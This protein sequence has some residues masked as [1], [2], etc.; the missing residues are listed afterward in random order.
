MAN[1]TIQLKFSTLTGKPATLAAGEPAYSYQSN[2]FFI[3]TPDGTGSINIGGYYYTSTLDSA[4]NSATGGT[5][6]K[7]DATGNASFNYIFANIVGTIEGT[8]AQATKLETPRFFN[9]TGDV[10]AVSASFDG[11]ANANFTLELT[12]TGVTNGTYGGATQIPVITVDVDG[13]ITSASNTSIS[14]DLNIKAD[15]GS[16][17][18]SLST[19]TLTFV[20]GDGI[21]TTIGPTDNVSFAV[22]NT[23]IRT[24]GPQTIDGTLNITGNLNVT[25]NVTTFGAEDLVINDPII[26]LANNN[27]GDVLDIGFVGKYDDGTSKELGL[28]HHAASDK[29]YLFTG[30]EGAVEDNNILNIADPTIVTATLIANLEGGTVS[31]L[32]SAISVADGGTGKNTFTTGSIVIGNGTGGLLELA[33]TS[34][35]GT[36]GNSGF[37]PVVT[38]DNY[39]RVSSVTTEEIKV[40]I[41]DITGIL[42][43]ANGG[44][45]ANTFTTGSLVTYNGSNFVSISNS[46]FTQTG[47]LSAANTVTSVSVDAYGRL[48][49]LTSSAIAIGADQITSGTLSVQRGGTGAGTFT[50]NGVLLGQG[51]SA[52]NTASSST[53]GHVL[54]INGSGVPTFSMISGGTF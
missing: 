40:T 18:I 45:G 1:T 3:G 32:A 4:T 50:T 54:T 30:Y 17:V 12:N 53:E 11:T 5:L 21:T 23:V 14:T 6:V 42:P 13:R 28:I 47:T 41:E 26:V 16:N 31:N 27:T 2:T 52:F 48:T 9:F 15:T 33:N 49:A 34:S 44:L 25:G 36:Y 22:D 43:V 37:V 19:D 29:F 35:A 51:T 39:G 38:V 20:G 8:A 10:D 46:S 24:T 7:R